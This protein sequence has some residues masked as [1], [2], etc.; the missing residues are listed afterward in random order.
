MGKG[1]GRSMSGI[2][3]EVEEDVKGGGF[4]KCEMDEKFESSE[5]FVEDREE[6]GLSRKITR[7][8]D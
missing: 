2:H 1:A 5:E 3:D 8:E 6:D 7:S 4:S